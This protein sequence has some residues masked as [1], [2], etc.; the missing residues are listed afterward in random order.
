MRELFW[1]GLRI[2][3]H[4]NNLFKVISFLIFMK[5]IGITTVTYFRPNS[6]VDE[7]RHSLTLRSLE[8]AS[9]LE[10]PV[11]MIDGGSPDE[12][13]REYEKRGANVE[14]LPGA[15]F[16]DRTRLGISKA[17]ERGHEV[18]MR[19]EI[20]KTPLISQIGR[21]IKPIL[22]ADAHFVVPHRGNLESYPE[23]QRCA[24]RFGDT[25]FKALTGLEIEL[26]MWGG[27]RVWRRDLSHYFLDESI[28]REYQGADGKPNNWA[29][30]FVPVVKII[31]DFFYTPRMNRI[32]TGIP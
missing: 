5:N 1:Q 25:W 26:D 23:E 32:A 13:L 20:E 19:L 12:F 30:Y 2:S 29:C 8:E 27:T 24:E 21:M 3:F 15:S 31:K 4:N 11:I 10:Y 7:V 6:R 28:D 9:N 16:G 14:Q 22:D 17:Y 18:I